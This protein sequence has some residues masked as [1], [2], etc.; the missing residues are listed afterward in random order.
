MTKKQKEKTEKAEGKTAAEAPKDLGCDD[1]DCPFH[2]KLRARGRTF[3]GRVTKKLPRRISIEFERMVYIRK[4]ERYTKSRT[5]IHARLPK[6]MESLISVGDLVRIQECRP[7]SKIINFVV[8]KKI[9]DF[10]NE[11]R[12]KK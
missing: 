10:G 9:K 2:G 7:L 3:E 6:C 8:V 12:G 4:Y 11:G 5:K 1:R